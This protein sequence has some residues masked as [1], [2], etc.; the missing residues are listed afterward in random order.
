MAFYTETVT[1]DHR[2]RFQKLWSGFISWTEVVG[3]SRAAAHLAQQGKYD[4]A[5]QCMMEVAKIKSAK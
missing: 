4:L 3:Y 5:K 1:I 2:S